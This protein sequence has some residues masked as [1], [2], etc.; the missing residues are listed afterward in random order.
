MNEAGIA[1]HA[2]DLKTRHIT[3]DALRG[4]AVMGILAMNITAFAMPEMAYINPAV[5]GGSTGG[6]F[7][8][9]LFGLILVDGKTRGL[10]SLLFGAS[11]MLIISRAQAKDENPTKVHYRRMAWLAAFGLFHFFFIWWGDILFLYAVIGCIAFLFRSWDVRRLVKWAVGIYAAGCLFFALA[12]GSMF[13]VEAAA[14]APDA[15][16][17]MVQE[18]EEM[19]AELGGDPA[20]TEEQVALHRGSYGEIVA[21]K[22]TE[23]WYGPL[24]TPLMMVFETLPL[25]LLGMAGLKSGLLLGQG[26]P[27]SYRKWAIW[28]IAIGG[29]LYA[30]IGYVV[31]ASAFD[32]LVTMNAN[33]AWTMPSRLIM[34]IGYAAALV[35]LI[36]TFSGSAFIARVAATGRA[37]FTNYLGTSIVMTTIFYGYGLGLYGKVGRAELWLYVLGA[38]LIMLLWSKP[39]LA[40]FRYGPLEW[41]WRSLARWELQPFRR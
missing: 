19:T 17:Q 10:F 15:S 39:W 34:I 20:V 9:W 2:A 18:Y 5:Y 23:N 33:M 4:F 21:N 29:L 26:P 27:S 3:L 25:M 12:M 7:V 16:A 24:M 35:M 28:G 37:A 30:A 14:N 40:R 32:P 31:H 11:L 22:I 41:L 38:W 36:N 8:A 13:F 6:D 1:V